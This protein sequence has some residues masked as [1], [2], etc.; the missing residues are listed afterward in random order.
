MWGEAG[1]P[2]VQ[3]QPWKWEH[4]NVKDNMKGKG[5]VAHFMSV[6]GKEREDRGY[7]SEAFTNNLAALET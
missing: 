4:K 3:G 6:D 2:V 5:S 7:D 1:R